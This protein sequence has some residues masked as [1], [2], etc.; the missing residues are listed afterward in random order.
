MAVFSCCDQRTL[1]TIFDDISVVV[2]TEGQRREEKRRGKREKKRESD[3][4][5]NIIIKPI[6]FSPDFFLWMNVAQM[7]SH[8]NKTCCRNALQFN[9]VVGALTLLFFSPYIS[10]MLFFS[11]LSPFF[12]L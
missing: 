7:R 1:A 12:L 8:I 4:Y 5:S 11:F 10:F 6:C 9:Y 3:K 2:D